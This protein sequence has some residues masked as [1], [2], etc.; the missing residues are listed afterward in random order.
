MRIANAVQRPRPRFRGVAR[1]LLA[2][3]LLLQTLP[4]AA[5]ESVAQR[6]F[7]L[8]V[9]TGSLLHG[10]RLAETF[11]PG[12]FAK[13]VTAAVVFEALESGEVDAE[14]LYPITEHAWRT[15]GAPARVT[16]MF[17]AVKSEVSVGDLVTGLV[18]H[19]ANDAAIALAEG[20]AG[21]ET[22]FAQRMNAYAER[23]GMR[24]SRFVNPTGFEDPRARISLRDLRTLA[25]HLMT[26][27][28]DRYRL[29]GTPEF[30]WNRILQRNK[31]EFVREV[32]GVDGL[33]T[34]YTES[35]GHGALVSAVRDGRRILVAASGLT[36]ESER[37]EEV[38]SLLNAAYQDFGRTVLFPADATVG[39]VRVFGGTATRVPVTGKGAVAVTLPRDGRDGFRA[40]LVYQ[41]PVPAPIS[42]GQPIA[43]LH[44]VRDGDLYQSVPLVAAAD[45]PVGSLADRARDGLLELLL[46]WW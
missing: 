15:G 19:H 28:P 23:I 45:V 32:P 20:L 31:T 42:R 29:Y 2:A 36:D 25:V 33:V 34:A 30:E 43:E 46:G 38:R 11:A 18:V 27:Y 35:A 13:L 9:D 17:A 6:F 4:A 37:N 12:N 44:L 7:I 39:T 41:G 3:L 22:A 24:D 40:E 16:T 14:T 10:N 1:A 21:S 26:A 8:E 5:L